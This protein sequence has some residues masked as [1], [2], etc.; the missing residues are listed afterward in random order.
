MLRRALERVTAPV[1]GA[2]GRLYAWFNE[3]SATVLGS[4][5]LPAGVTAN[6]ITTARSTLVLPTVLLL[7]HGHT[8]LPAACVVANVTLDYVDGAVARHQRQVLL[9]EAKAVADGKSKSKRPKL[10]PSARAQ[11]E[12]ETWG[13]YYDAIADKAFAIPVWLCLFQQVGG[14]GEHPILQAALL[15]HVAVEGFSCFVR[16]R[17][18]YTEPSPLVW[19]DA[20]RGPGAQAQTANAQTPAPQS[21]A[22]S[23]VVAGIVG[24][25]KQFAA[26]LGTALVM[27]PLTQP[28]GALLVCASVP[29]AVASV[30]Q[31]S[32]R[33]SVVYAEVKQGQAVTADTL[34]YLEH[35]RKL[36]SSLIVGVRSDDST[37]LSR[38]AATTL[39]A[40]DSTV[41]VL[42]MNPSVD[43]V[44]ESH[45]LP[46]A[47]AIADADFLQEFGIDVVAVPSNLTFDA[48]D[49]H[50][51][52]AI[53]PVPV[54]GSGTSGTT[55]G[56]KPI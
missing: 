6:N 10:L 5:R 55:S 29:L 14:G 28:L 23:V 31:K 26:M 51:K 30:L 36:G 24:K 32:A 42:R 19:V 18:Y 15:S 52:A 44:L 13:A 43:A 46:P 47:R 34:D 33:H 50:N 40:E 9:A 7:S 39:A 45:H 21:P 35:C 53:V 16:T 1:V 54:G 11:R 12:S 3:R 48:I 22:S 8:V 27:V 37:S 2:N 49:F 17:A 25:T 56:S 20:G 41:G 38:G 4:G